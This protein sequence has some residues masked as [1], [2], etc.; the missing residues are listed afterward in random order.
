MA[1]RENGSKQKPLRGKSVMDLAQKLKIIQLLEGGEKVA[2]VAKRFVVNEST[3]RST[4]DNK[5]KIRD[6]ASKLGPHAKFCKI[7]RSGMI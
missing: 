1:P 7:S 3:I 4:R 5:Q 2:A 6:S